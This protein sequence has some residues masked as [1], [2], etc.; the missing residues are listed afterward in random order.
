ML[1]RLAYL[2][3]GYHQAA[4]W[5]AELEVPDSVDVTLALKRC[6]RWR[7]NH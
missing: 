3:Y 2:G 4:H 1:I 6:S 5:P 7:P